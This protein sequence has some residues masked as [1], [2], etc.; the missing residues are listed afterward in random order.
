MTAVTH[1]LGTVSLP[2]AGARLSATLPAILE[3]RAALVVLSAGGGEAAELEV[4]F[5]ENAISML[6]VV[7]SRPG[8]QCQYH[9]G[10]HSGRLP[11]TWWYS[12]IKVG[13]CRLQQGLPHIGAGP[14]RRP[15]TVLV[16]HSRLPVLVAGSRPESLA[17][18]R[19]LHQS[20]SAV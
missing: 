13:V 10:H 1:G 14:A 2:G 6:G 3:S 15:G 18:R 5:V 12:G 19:A 8:A 7:G 9:A 20:R 17:N 11:L 16:T 4:P